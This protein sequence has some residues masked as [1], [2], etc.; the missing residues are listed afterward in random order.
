MMNHKETGLNQ[1]C[2]LFIVG[3]L[4][5]IAYA[6]YNAVA[7]KWSVDSVAIYVLGMFVTKAMARLGGL[8]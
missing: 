5:L 7:G 4:A 1:Y 6:F 3:L 8:E 2:W